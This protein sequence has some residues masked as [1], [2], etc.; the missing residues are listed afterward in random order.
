MNNIAECSKTEGVYTLYF[1]INLKNKNI[2][3]FS[4]VAHPELLVYTAHTVQQQFRMTKGSK[5]NII[6]CSIV[7]YII[8]F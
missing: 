8:I 7:L 1:I 5:G 2:F 3:H 6:T 4:S